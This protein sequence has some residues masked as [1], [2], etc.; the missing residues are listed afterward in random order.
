MLKNSVDFLLFT[1][2][3]ATRSAL[4]EDSTQSRILVS[5]R[6]SA[7]PIVPIF[8]GQA[9]FL[10]SLKFEDGNDWLCR[11]IGKALPFY[12]A[13]N[14]KIAISGLYRVG[15]LKSCELVGTFEGDFVQM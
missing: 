2:L 7:Q 14:P 10:D 9:G 13:Q 8:I 1:E 4:F 6:F 3:V 11:N 15:S 5:Y 12:A